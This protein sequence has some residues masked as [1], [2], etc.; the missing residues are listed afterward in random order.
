MLFT[1]GPRHEHRTIGAAVTAAQPGAIILVERGAYR[2]SLRIEKPLTIRAAEGLGSVVIEAPEVRVEV[3]ANVKLQQL[4]I[5]QARHRGWLA[6]RR[7]ADPEPGKPDQSEA[8]RR[9][10]RDNAVRI[11]AGAAAIDGCSISAESGFGIMVRGS[12]TRATIS[13]TR[14]WRAV[15]GLAAGDGAVVHATGLDV[16]DVAL[17]GIWIGRNAQAEIHSASLSGIRGQALYV[18]AGA[19]VVVSDLTVAES[20]TAIACFDADTS[21]SI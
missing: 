5:R 16:A 18:D 11:S 13:A 2:E 7:G 1:V 12:G 6:G 3:A 19:K 21:V 17:D 20:K 8:T 15:A 9:G 10:M 4:T 14:V